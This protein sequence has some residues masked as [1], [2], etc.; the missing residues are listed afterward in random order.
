MN[1]TWADLYVHHFKQYFGKPYDV[2]HFHPDADSPPLQIAIFDQPYPHYRIFASIGLS[3][4]REAVQ[5]LGEVILLADAAW[6]EMPLLFANSLFYMIR[7]RIHLGSRFA[8]GGIDNLEPA[9]A[10]HFDKVAL[11]YTVA[12]GFPEGFERL[13]WNNEVG[14]VYQAIF[15][16]A[17]ELDFLT[18]QGARGVRAALPK[19]RTPTCAAYAVHR[20]FDVSAP[21]CWHRSRACCAGRAAGKE[22]LPAQPSRA[23]GAGASSRA[24]AFL[25]GE[26]LGVGWEDREGCPA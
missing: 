25:V 2:Q 7:R 19:P 1:P 18:R 20:A 15:I 12:D 14:L 17:A 23:Q 9:F 26:I 3:N 11:Y 4:H 6:R 10:E 13:A 22:Q 21:W 24:L 16:S 8:I 5:D